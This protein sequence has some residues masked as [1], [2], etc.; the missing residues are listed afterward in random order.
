LWGWDNLL[1]HFLKIDVVLVRGKAMSTSE[2]SYVTSSSASSSYRHP[3]Q[4]YQQQQQQHQQHQHQHQQTPSYADHSNVN[5]PQGSRFESMRVPAS[6]SR[7]KVGVR[8]RPPF[9][10]EVARDKQPFRPVVTII[11]GKKGDADGTAGRRNVG[12]LPKVQLAV[13]RQGGRTRDFYYDYAFGPTCSP[14]EVYDTVAGPIVQDV[15][16]G[17]NG[18]VFA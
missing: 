9:Q 6:M 18:T 17:F 16:Q 7:V 2:R 14:D 5:A 15:L 8:C 1:L 3:Q 12:E 13:D 10:D 11:Q 4:Q